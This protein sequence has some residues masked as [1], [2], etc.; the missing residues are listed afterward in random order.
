LKAYGEQV[1]AYRL[2]ARG[3]SPGTAQ[4][5]RVADRDL[6]APTNRGWSLLSMLPIFV[7]ILAF[8]GPMAVVIDVTAGERERQ[9]LEPLLATPTSRRKLVA[10]KLLAASLF[11]VLAVALSLVLFK[12][13]LAFGPTGEVHLSW[14]ALTQTVIGLTPMVLF[15]TGLLTFIAAG[16]KSVK[17][18]QSWL[19]LLVFV[20]MLPSMV[21]SMSPVKPQLW[22]MAVPFLSQHH[23]LQRLLRNEGLSPIEWSLYGAS[24]VALAMVCWALSARRYTDERL[25]IST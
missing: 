8:T 1:G 20:P 18:A 4:A 14:W 25:A 16:A 6:V 17:E 23:L 13:G 22:M 21:L 24:G 10:G 5:L 19:G 9:S 12:L 7:I 2:L 11:G 15:G 3:L